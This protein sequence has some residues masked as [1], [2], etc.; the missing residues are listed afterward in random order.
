MSRAS[1]SSAAL[2]PVEIAAWLAS[3]GFL[4]PAAQAVARNLLHAAGVTN[5]RKQAMAA[6]KL[7]RA[8][9]VLAEHVVLACSGCR[10]LAVPGDGQVR[11]ETDA[12]NCAICGG[13]NNRRAAETMIAACER[14]GL[15]RLLV[16]GGTGATHRELETLVQGSSVELRLIDGVQRTPNKRDALA[17]VTWADLVVVWASTP[18]PHKV[19][20]SYT[21]QTRDRAIRT[22]TVSRRGVSALCEE[23]T[24]SIAL[25]R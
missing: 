19:S 9:D 6:T 13:S 11:V 16:V 23:V 7:E 2:E 3:E 1:A 24:K 15:R 17:D 22:I 14:A 10:D 21:A 12:A 8:H 4:T 20:T 25:A 18:L 5:P